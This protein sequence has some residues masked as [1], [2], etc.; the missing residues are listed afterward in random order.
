MRLGFQRGSEIIGVLEIVL[1]SDAHNAPVV[2]TISG[3]KPWVLFA[4][5]VIFFPAQVWVCSSWCDWSITVTIETDVILSFAVV[6]LCCT[7]LFR[8]AG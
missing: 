4:N 5:C 6:E 2:E 3:L 1:F 7:P 8:R